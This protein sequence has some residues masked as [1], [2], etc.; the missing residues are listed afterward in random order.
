[1]EQDIKN[2]QNELLRLTQRLIVLEN[3]APV[4]YDLVIQS[5]R[6]QI[7]QLEKRADN[8]GA[9]INVLESARIEQRKLNAELLKKPEPKTSF[10]FRK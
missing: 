10:W 7:E 6:G 9:R 8:H 4:N 5:L 2:L 3:K 1:M